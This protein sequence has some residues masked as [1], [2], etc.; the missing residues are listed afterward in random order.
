[1]SDQ[2]ILQQL[3]NKGFRLTRPRQAVVD[4]LLS[5]EGWLTPEQILE[6]ASTGCSSLGLATVYRTLALLSDESFIRRIH[7]EDGCHGY[8]RA[9]LD[10]GH[11]LICRSCHQVVEFEGFNKIEILIQSIEDETGYFIE[12]HLL[13]LVGLCSRC[14]ENS[15]D[16]DRQ[17]DKR[18][19]S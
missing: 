16:I 2:S 19:Q 1:M 8:A 9:D 4:V 12:E 17:Y 10:H 13:E 6:K 5:A 18:V 7:F 14:S 3:Q 15:I 11:H